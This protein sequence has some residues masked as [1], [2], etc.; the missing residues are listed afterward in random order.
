MRK[1]DAQM[2]SLKARLND[3]FNRLIIVICSLGMMMF[4]ALLFLAYRIGQ[5][6]AVS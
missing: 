6:S 1:P 5:A 3:P 4:A 2:K